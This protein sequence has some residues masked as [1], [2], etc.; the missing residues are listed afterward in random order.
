MTNPE[1][2]PDT[3][4]WATV[5][6]AVAVIGCIGILGAALITTLFKSSSNSTP[7]PVVIHS[8]NVSNIELPAGNWAGTIASKDGSFST[9]VNLSFQSN[10]LLNEVCGTYDAPEI[11]CSGT[12]TLVSAKS[13]SFVFVEKTTSS[14][15]Y[16][17]NTCYDH[18]QKLTESTITYG[19]SLTGNSNDI[20][21]TGTLMRP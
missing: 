19:C 17:I 8:Q 6:I 13:D 21:S 18:I 4:V 3:K 2:K 1:P 14:A 15:S 12:L 16:C 10:C 5:T 7:A 9:K 20:R 11:Q